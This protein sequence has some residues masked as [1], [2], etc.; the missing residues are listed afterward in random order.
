MT[1]MIAFQ[2]FQLPEVMSAIIFD[3]ISGV[4]RTLNLITVITYTILACVCVCVFA[5]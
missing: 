4:K 5:S 1:S 3:V 2:K